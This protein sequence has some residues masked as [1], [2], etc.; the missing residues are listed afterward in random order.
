MRKLSLS[1]ILFFIYHLLPAQLLNA[2][3]ETWSTQTV[4]IVDT[5][6]PQGKVLKVG[7][8]QTGNSAARLETSIQSFTP[9]SAS[10][11]LASGFT[12]GYPYFDK[13]D[14]IKLYVK[15]NVANADTAT[16]HIELLNDTTLIRAGNYYIT[17]G[18]AGSWTEISIPLEV[19]DTSVAPLSILIY[20]NNTLD[21][22]AQLASFLE[23]DN[24]RCYHKGALQTNLPN[25]SFETWAS[26]TTKDVAN[27]TSSNEL[28][29]QF[30][31]DSINCEQTTASQNG[32]YAVKLHTID[33]FGT[34]LPGGIV[35]G[36]HQLDAAQNPSSIPTIAVNTRYASLSGYL[37]FTKKGTD[38]G[39]ASIYM[40][41]NGILIGEGH[42]FQ[43]TTIA[44]YTQFEAK[45]AYDATFTGIPDSAT[46]VFLTSNDPQNATGACILWLDNIQLNKF[47][48]GIKQTPSALNQIYPNPFSGSLQVE[49]AS[50]KANMLLTAVD[51]KVILSQECLH[52]LNSINTQALSPGVYILQI[53][54]GA[55][56]QTLKVVRQ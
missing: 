43:T 17:S 50:E 14:T 36:V 31:L 39:E 52:G 23:V 26:T 53:N 30:G 22:D 15:Y 54:D 27:W 9:T 46:I 11:V 18:S 28:F 48:L 32:T 37:K 55:S 41:K 44:T 20:I 29:A 10:L 3:F 24:I 38:E 42:F 12:D 19:V 21:Y 13:V 45:I 5:W 8:A 51:G 7:N 34:F 25:F 1:A 4:D 16:F 35:S 33:I 49:I 56:T 6:I 2:N 47:A 40:F